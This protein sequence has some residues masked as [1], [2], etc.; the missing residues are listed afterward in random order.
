MIPKASL[1][2]FSRFSFPFAAGCPLFF[3]LLSTIIESTTGEVEMRA[4][5]RV[6]N[7]Y[8]ISPEAHMWREHFMRNQSHSG[9]APINISRLSRFN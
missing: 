6:R 1:S 7:F 8:S 9:E 5:S 4:S 2:I 3:A